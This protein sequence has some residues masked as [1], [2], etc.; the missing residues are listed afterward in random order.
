MSCLRLRQAGHADR[1]LLAFLCGPA[2]IGLSRCR[3]P[4]GLRDGGRLVRDSQRLG[5]CS[6]AGRARCP[7]GGQVPEPPDVGRLAAAHC[8]AEQLRGQRRGRPLDLVRNVAREIQHGPEVHLGPVNA[9]CCASSGSPAVPAIV[10]SGQ[11]WASSHGVTAGPARL[12][13][14]CARTPGMPERC[15]ASRTSAPLPA[16]LWLS[17]ALTP[18]QRVGH[19]AGTEAGALGEKTGVAVYL[20]GD[21]LSRTSPAS[22]GACWPSARADSGILATWLTRS[23]GNGPSTKR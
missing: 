20:P 15:P 10:S 4:C 21:R 18:R 7:T 3:S 23:R 5:A 19:G 2:A 12:R 16:V 8:E 17:P 13:R 9:E 14:P 11:A 6:A 1:P 22:K